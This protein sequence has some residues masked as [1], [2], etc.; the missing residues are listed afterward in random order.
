M[1]TT[2]RSGSVALI[3]LMAMA[4]LLTVALGLSGLAMQNVKRSGRDTSGNVALQA[5]QA[6]VELQTSRCFGQIKQNNGYF[7]ASINNVASDLAGITP[8]LTAVTRVIPIVGGEQAW[9][10]STV[11]HNGMR[12]SVRVRVFVRDVGIWNNAVF[13][14][15][16]ASG[17]SIN[18]NVDI[19]GSMHLLGEGEKYS[20]LNG[21]GQ[22]DPAEA[23]SD[24]NSNGVWDP[25]ESF[26]DT[27]GD[28]VWSSAEPYN[29][30]NSNGMYDPPFT[31]TDLNSSF[32]GTAYIGNNYSGMPAALEAQVP[33]L[34]KPGGIETLQAEVRVKHGRIG[35]SGTATL[36]SNDLID[37][38]MSKATLDGVYV[39]DGFTGNQGASSV[40][41]DNG[42]SEKYDLDGYGLT[43][44]LIS[45]IGSETYIDPQGGNWTNHH[46]YYQARSL[47]VPVSTIKATTPAFSY[48]PDAYGNS[49]K[50][51]P[52]TTVNNVTVPATLNITG[53]VRIDGDLQ[54]GQQNDVVRYTGNGTL[55]T[56][57]SINV[58][59]DFLPMPGLKFPI[60]TRVGLVAHKNMNLAMGAG[61]AQLSMA[62]AFYAQGTIYSA[63]QNQIAGTF[64]ANYYDL[65]KNV[66]NIYQVPALPK[67]M[68][69]AMPGDFTIYAM[70]SRTWRERN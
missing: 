37:G 69:P 31:V 40:F 49:I 43:F 27:N 36:G 44:P 61:S 52:Q 13:A 2:L 16:G 15:S 3:S 14:G 9:I 35:V 45:G 66:P 42:T 21:N 10:S 39:S 34:L 18:G 41:S 57:G 70:K 8:N 60:D 11:I 47:T 5:A 29:D 63:K 1:K 65:G 67:N 38:G 50:F 20:D 17:Q 30:S 51:T 46:A 68:P 62:G 59:G 28:G 25:G 53:V 6:G 48:G 55:F 26:T 54:I 24:T 56:E 23:F 12:R 22:W 33:E 7:L 58:D 4:L 19:R 64:V 32:A